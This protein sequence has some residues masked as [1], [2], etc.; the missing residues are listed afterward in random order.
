MIHYLFS[1]NLEFVFETTG[2]ID[3]QQAKEIEIS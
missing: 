2:L 1:K 3:L